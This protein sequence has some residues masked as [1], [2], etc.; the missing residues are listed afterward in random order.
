MDGNGRDFGAFYMKY[1]PLVRRVLAQ[2]GVRPSDLDDVAQDAFVTINRLLPE[3]EGRSSVETWLHAVTWRVAASHLRSAR[4]NDVPSDPAL[5][6]VADRA[7]RDAAPNARLHAT[8]GQLDE[9]QRDVVVLHEVGGFSI[10]ELSRLTGNARATVRDRLDRGRTAV[11]RRLW[12]SLTD[13]EVPA[14]LDRL[15]PGQA[16]GPVRPEGPSP[17]RVVGNIAISTVDDIVLLLA[18]GPCTVATLE[19][20]IEEMFAALDQYPDGIRH[21]A[22]VESSSTP[23]DREARQLMAWGLGKFGPKIRAAGWAVEDIQRKSLVASIVNTCLF[24]GGAPAN[25]RFF[26]AVP[27]AARWLTEYGAAPP[28][29]QIVAHV[30]EMRSHLDPVR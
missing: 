17:L 19:A 5:S 20:V 2:R 24:L 26:D 16:D 1:A 15:A 28:S 30:E 11:G 9:E 23:P 29:E 6:M 25:I 8:L 4:R 7:D 21:L 22:I 10:S 27:R 14:W 12:R 3:F 18:R 13:G